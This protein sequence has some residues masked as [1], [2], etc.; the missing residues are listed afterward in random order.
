MTCLKNPKKVNVFRAIVHPNVSKTVG[1]MP[2]AQS[3]GDDYDICVDNIHYT[4][5][6]LK[7]QIV[8]LTLFTLVS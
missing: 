3:Y 7:N 1:Y 5:I 8:F 2:I 4:G 6:F